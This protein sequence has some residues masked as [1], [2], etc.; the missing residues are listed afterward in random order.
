MYPVQ[1]LFGEVLQDAL[2]AAAANAAAAARARPEPPVK[3]A[4]QELLLRSLCSNY[5]PAPSVLQLL[6]HVQLQ[7]LYV[8]DLWEHSIDPPPAAL[9]AL[10]GLTSL[11]K[12]HL[13]SNWCRVC[14]YEPVVL[15]DLPT[16]LQ[17]LTQLTH[18]KLHVDVSALE[19]SHAQLLILS[20]RELYATFVCGAEADEDSDVVDLRYLSALSTLVWGRVWNSG[21]APLGLVLPPQLQFL[22]VHSPVPKLLD[23]VSLKSLYASVATDSDLAMLASLALL[24]DVQALEVKFSCCPDADHQEDLHSSDESDDGLDLG[25]QGSSAAVNAPTMKRGPGMSREA[26]QALAESLGSCAGL[27]AIT[28][29]STLQEHEWS[30]SIAENLRGVMWCQHLTKLTGL[31]ALCVPNTMPFM[32]HD[33]LHL[34]AASSLQSLLLRVEDGLD[35]FAAG[36]TVRHAECRPHLRH[37]SLQGDTVDGFNMLALLPDIAKL[38]TL[39]SLSLHGDRDLRVRT[40]ICCRLPP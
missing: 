25:G 10:G 21:D 8:L 27:K 31:E 30:K 2:A 4:G 11:Q 26:V 32:R 20:L 5:V 29:D 12:L 36:A 18:L 37:L 13:Q 3:A 19:P 16:V 28:L 15:E 1:Q 6:K 22:E 33:L 14:T 34:M 39:R 35:D 40:K 23:P 38:T 24:A 17:Q 9:S 7:Q